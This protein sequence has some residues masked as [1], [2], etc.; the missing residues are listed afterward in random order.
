MVCATVKTDQRCGGPSEV[1]TRPDLHELHCRLSQQAAA[2]RARLTVPH[3][4]A[5]AA[6]VETAKS[7][8]VSSER[9]PSAL[10]SRKRFRPTMARRFPPLH[11]N[12]GPPVVEGNAQPLDR[13]L[14]VTVQTDQWL[15]GWAL[16][17]VL[18]ESA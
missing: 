7:L 16:H 6:A 8:P 2:A 14:G 10:R 11:P 12:L 5:S 13:V 17:S 4:L 9:S 15:V 3:E 18:H 1:S